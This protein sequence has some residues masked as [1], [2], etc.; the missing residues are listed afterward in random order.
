MQKKLYRSP[1]DGILLG[2]AAGL[3]NYFNID[4]VIIR[5]VIVIL[6]LVTKGWP[7]LILYALMFLI[8]PVDPAQAKVSSDQEPKDVTSSEPEKKEEESKEEERNS[9][10]EERTESTEEAER[11]DSGQNM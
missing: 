3:G 1:K 9:A 11:M 8:I 10:S 5:I 6:A 4:S 7:I 2:V